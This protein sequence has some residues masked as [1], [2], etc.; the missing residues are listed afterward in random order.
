MLL[1]FFSDHLKA[2]FLNIFGTLQP[3][4]IKPLL[5][6]ENRLY[7]TFCSQKPIFILLVISEKKI[8]LVVI[9]NIVIGTKVIF[10]H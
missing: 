8:I 1:A 5:C 2:I 7:W 3:D 6:T 9:N 4:Y 10:R